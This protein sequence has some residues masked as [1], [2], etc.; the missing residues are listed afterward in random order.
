MNQNKDW[1]ER[2]L[3]AG[4]GA[5]FHRCA[6]QVNPYEYVIRHNKPGG[7][8]DEKEYNEE[9]L[10]AL[11]KTGIEVIAITDHFAIQ[12][13]KNL[14]AEAEAEGLAVFPGFEAETKD[15]IHMLCLFRTKDLGGKN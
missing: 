6:L 13:S 7:F 12:D 8:R 11:K 3:S 14:I 4:N 9:V 15:G 10:C 1:I 5:R 2:L